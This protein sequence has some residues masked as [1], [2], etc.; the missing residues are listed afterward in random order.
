MKVLV[1]IWSYNAPA[2]ADVVKEL[3][4]RKD[5]TIVVFDAEPIAIQQMSAGLIDAMVVQNPYQMGYQG[6]RLMKALYEKDQKT[7]DK[8]LP[9][10]GQP[11]GDLYDTGLK[12]VVPNGQSPLAHWKFAAK[13]EFLTLDAFKQWLARYSLEGS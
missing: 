9:H 3:G 5:Y 8:M 11:E 6:V 2:I 13:T 1:G 12:I 10:H 7:V 4:K